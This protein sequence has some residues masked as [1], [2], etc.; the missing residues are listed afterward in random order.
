M[1]AL[2]LSSFL[3]FS[4]SLSSSLALS[5]SLARAL[6]LS[7]CLSVSLSFILARDAPSLKGIHDLVSIRKRSN[8]VI[9]ICDSPTIFPHV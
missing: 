3:S 8:G 7:L 1:S 4:L 5:L 2:A 6:F 9:L